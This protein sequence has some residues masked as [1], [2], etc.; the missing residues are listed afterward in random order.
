MHVM[1]WKMQMT[2]KSSLPVQNREKYK[3]SEYEDMQIDGLVRYFRL[4]SY[5]ELKWFLRGVKKDQ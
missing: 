4:E 1:G 2:A 5:S 3:H